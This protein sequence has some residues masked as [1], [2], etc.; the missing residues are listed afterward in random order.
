MARRRKIATNQQANGQRKS[1]MADGANKAKNAGDTANKAD[2]TRS[3]GKL[4]LIDRAVH[5]VAPIWGAKRAVARYKAQRFHAAASYDAA[6]RNRLNA[7]FNPKNSTADAAVLGDLDVLIPRSRDLI[8]NTPMGRAVMLSYSR[9]VIGCGIKPTPN[10]RDPQG[11]LDETFNDEAKAQFFDWANDP[12]Q[13]DVEGRLTFW[14]MQ[15]Q[16]IEQIVEAGELYFREVV[17]NDPTRANPLALQRLEIDQ[18]NLDLDQADSGRE[19]RR[20]IEIDGQ[21]R[22]VAYHFW[23]RPT[24]DTGTFFPQ[25]TVVIKADDILHVYLQDRPGQTHG[26]PILAAVIPKIRDLSEYDNWELI[27]TRTQAAPAILVNREF[28]DEG[29]EGMDDENDTGLEIDAAVWGPGLTVTSG[30]GETVT[31]FQPSRPG[32]QY[33]PFTEQQKRYIAAGSNISYE[34]L[35]R[36]F[37]Q[38]TYSSQRQGAHEDQRAFKVYQDLIITQLCNRAWQRF[39]R[40]GVMSG[41]LKAPGFFS[42]PRRWFRVTWRAPGWPWIDPLKEAQSA[43]ILLNMNLTTRE[44]LIASLHGEHYAD[45]FEQLKREEEQQDVIGLAPSAAPLPKKPS[46]KDGSADGSAGQNENEDT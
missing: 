29:M 5:A 26:V 23:D 24:N 35:S 41:K 14:D 16:A 34:Q 40:W 7:D 20:G 15:R 39:V 44:K 6:R 4:S 33:R 19:V 45:I 27:A 31:G 46:I 21:R 38:G 32:G 17:V 25:K 18:L 8:R 2:K 3:V 37:S 36:D 28:P 43:G 9:N 42:D 22:A 12:S 1:E 13:C 30:L 10:V 11:K